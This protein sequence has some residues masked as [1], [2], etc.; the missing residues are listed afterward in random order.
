M[1]RR[2]PQQTVLIADNAVAGATIIRDERGLPWVKV[3]IDMPIAN[4]QMNDICFVR[5]NSKYI[6]PVKTSVPYLSF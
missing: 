4:N 1:V 2:F 3:I 5:A 6:R